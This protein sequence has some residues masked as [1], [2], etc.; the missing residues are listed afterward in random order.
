MSV[1][2]QFKKDIFNRKVRKEGAKIAKLKWK[3]NPF[4]SFEHNLSALCGYL[5]LIN[6]NRIFTKKM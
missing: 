3:K 2:V 5:I 6:C 4:A 1:K